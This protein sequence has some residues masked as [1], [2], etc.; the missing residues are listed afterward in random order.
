MIKPN[1]LKSPNDNRDCYTYVL[2]NGL[3]IFLIYDDDTTVASCAMHV[4]V[5]YFED[6]LPGIAHFLEHMLFN[7]TKKYPD[8]KEFSSFIS[9]HGGMQ[10]A[11]TTNTHTC[12]YYSVTDDG[13]LQALDMFGEFFV[14]PLLDEHCIARERESVNSEHLKNV[15]ND[16]WRAHELLKLAA[17][18]GHH[19]KKFGT[20]SN[21]TLNVAS[22][23]C[24][25]KEFFLTQYSADKMTLVISSNCELDK[26]KTHVDRIF[27]R[28]EKRPLNVSLSPSMQHAHTH[29]HVMQPIL[30]KNTIIKFVPIENTNSLILTWELAHFRD[31]PTKSP[32]DFICHLIGNEMKNSIHYVLTNAGYITQFACYVRETIHSSCILTI[33]IKLSPLGN[34]HKSSIIS[35]IYAYLSHIKKTLLTNNTILEKIYNDQLKITLYNFEHFEK[36]TAI[37]SMLGMC[38]LINDYTINPK[39]I[40]VTNIMQDHFSDDI[41]KNMLTILDQMIQRDGFTIIYG[42]HCDIDDTFLVFPNYGTRYKIVDELDCD[43]SRVDDDAILVATINAHNPFISV[44]KD[45]Y[46][47]D[48]PVRSPTPIPNQHRIFAYS[49]NHTGFNVPDVMIILKID[50]PKACEHC[51]TSTCILLYLNTLFTEINHDLY[52][53]SNAMYSFDIGYDMGKIAVTL[54]GNYGK[55]STVYTY[56]LN[57]LIDPALITEKSFDMA[58]YAMLQRGENYKFES[59]YVKVGDIFSKKRVSNYYDANDRQS[60]IDGITRDKMVAV[61]R[62]VFSYRNVALLVS[63]NTTKKASAYICDQTGHILN[64]LCNNTYDDPNATIASLSFNHTRSQNDALISTIAHLIVPTMVHQL[65]YHNTSS[66]TYYEINE[67]VNE[68]NVAVSHYVYIG[69]MPFN[70]DISTS[71]WIADYCLMFLLDACIGVEYFDTLRT[72]EM[73]GYIVTSKIDSIGEM[74]NAHY[75]YVFIVQS[76]DKTIKEITDR[77]VRFM[78]DF[79]ARINSMG[80]EEFDTIKKSYIANIGSEY[81]NLAC[82]MNFVF[83]TEIESGYLKFDFKDVVIGVCEKL[84]VNDLREFYERK[85]GTSRSDVIVQLDKVK[86]SDSGRMVGGAR[87]LVSPNMQCC[88]CT[89]HQMKFR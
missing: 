65:S 22:L 45:M 9:K 28:I 29:T 88:L 42:T 86:Q 78:N 16:G 17:V 37:E 3:R 41:K 19:Y 56:L 2:E 81:T 76:P 8:E 84:T 25:V 77:N 83:T 31:T 68:E 62:R 10:N 53:C 57:K 47:E 15:N 33:D 64:L 85:F 69:N 40:F 60:V 52:L 79:S 18:D 34:S 7:G 13:F 48:N 67:N 32:T 35:S 87:N 24:L 46:K 63:G 43:E 11:Y 51:Y 39:H 71:A 55:I 23:A 50:I 4:R 54:S 66:T 30:K 61:F 21:D 58:K 26:L 12:Y 82:M 59:P 44:A 6:T 14:S 49:F 73:F 75:Y 1:V 27:S 20:G 80:V 72:K 70:C 74:N 36:S 38:S 5:G 89:Y